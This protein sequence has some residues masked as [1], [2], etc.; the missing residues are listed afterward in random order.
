M[1]RKTTPTKTK[2]KDL[3]PSQPSPLPMKLSETATPVQLLL[4]TMDVMSTLH[5]DLQRIVDEQQLMLMDVLPALHPD[6]QWI[7]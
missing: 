2:Y 6:L 1:L 4:E 5:P 3:F 7:I